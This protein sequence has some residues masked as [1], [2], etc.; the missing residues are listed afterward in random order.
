MIF[1]RLVVIATCMG[2]W[3]QQQWPTLRGV[4][5]RQPRGGTWKKAYQV[6]NPSRCT[7]M[8]MARFCQTGIGVALCPVTC[9]YCPLFE[10]KR[11]HN[12]E[13]RQITMLPIVVIPNSQGADGVHIIR[14]DLIDVA[15]QSRHGAITSSGRRHRGCGHNVLGSRKAPNDPVCAREGMKRKGKLVYIAT[16]A[17]YGTLKLHSFPR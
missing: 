3:E 7:A 5:R 1:Q 13:K 9:G 2:Q 6:S 14:R 11:R 17:T 15:I 4:L 10:Y 16:K 8:G 12:F